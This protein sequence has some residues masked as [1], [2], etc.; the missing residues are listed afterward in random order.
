MVKYSN[1]ESAE[2]NNKATG[3]VSK[4]G[5]RKVGTFPLLSPREQHRFQKCK[6]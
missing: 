3:N 2:V 5:K 4:R 6:I 1:S